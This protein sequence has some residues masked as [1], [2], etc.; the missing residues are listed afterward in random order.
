MS[1]V[2]VTVCPDG[3]LLIRG[4]YELRSADGQVL[5]HDRSV[6]A[7]CRCGRSQLKPLCDGSHKT[8]RFADRADAASIAHVLEHARPSPRPDR[9]AGDC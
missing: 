6:L 3:P 9:E 4:A 5:S 2:S 1:D 8:S 7:L